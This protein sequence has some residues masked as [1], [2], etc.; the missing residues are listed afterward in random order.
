MKR[1][2][3]LSLDMFQDPL[4]T[5]VGLILFGT[6]WAVIPSGKTMPSRKEAIGPFAQVESLQTETATL[7]EKIATIYMKMAL[8]A[9]R[10]AER[11]STAAKTVELTKAVAAESARVG[12]LERQVQAATAGSARRD[13]A[14]LLDSGKKALALLREELELARLRQNLRAKQGM[15]SLLERRALGAPEMGDV[16]TGNLLS[17]TPSNKEPRYIE[18]AEGK[19]YP[20][21][22]FHYKI[23]QYY[24]YARCVRKKE[25]G[26]SLDW[27]R[28]YLRGL[29]RTGDCVVFL[30]HGKSF[31]LFR[32]A[33]AVILANGF[34]VGWYP[35]VSDTII[36]SSGGSRPR[37]HRAGGN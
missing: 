13:A 29:D 6:I 35:A 21:D 9:E 8:A 36:G 15:V 26:E 12:E 32:Q 33:R 34:D 4:L 23:E 25:T 31:P 30:L 19:L 22:D 18:V 17:M 28:V 16:V 20:M 1:R 14:E 5:V 24:S 11:R 7:R 3:V 27:L 37:T 10:V 2:P